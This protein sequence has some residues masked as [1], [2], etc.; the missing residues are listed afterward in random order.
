MPLSIKL[1]ALQGAVY[2]KSTQEYLLFGGISDSQED[3]KNQT[4]LYNPNSATKFSRLV[5][6]MITP[7]YAFGYEI[8]GDWVYAI[9]GGSSDEEG[10]LI[11]LNKC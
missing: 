7:R 4:Y 2:L 9:A 3:V 5:A 6:K 8:I 1:H 10:D 11:I